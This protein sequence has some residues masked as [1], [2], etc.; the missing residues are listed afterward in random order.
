[1]VCDSS[2]ALVGSEVYH[3]VHTTTFLWKEL[4][5][6]WGIPFRGFGIGSY[7]WN[8]DLNPAR[9]TD[10]FLRF[11]E[12]IVPAI[13][14]ANTL[15]VLPWRGRQHVLPNFRYL[16]AKLQ[17]HSQLD[18]KRHFYRQTDA[19]RNLLRVDFVHSVTEKTNKWVRSSSSSC[20]GRIR[21][22]SCSLYPQNE[23]GPSIK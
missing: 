7:T 5:S 3:M 18:G 23:I 22:D 12:S 2:K 6:N 15:T 17:R 11:T 1:M 21:F 9:R 19:R 14:H 10:D 13:K 8:W 4:V 20:L 16:S